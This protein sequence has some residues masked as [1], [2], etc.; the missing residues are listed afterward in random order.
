MSMNTSTRVRST[1]GKSASR[2]K[3][4]GLTFLLVALYV[5]NFGNQAVLGL[6]AQP[7][8]D[9][10]GLTASQIGVMG[11]SFFAA[12]L[13]G[14]LLAGTLNKWVTLRWSLVILALTWAVVMLPTIFAAGFAMLLIGRLL[15]GLAEGP[16][17]SLIFTAAY[18][19][20]PEDRRSLPATII[21]SAASL[22]KVAVAPVLTVVI[23]QFGWRAGFIT[24][25]GVAALWCV[26]WL[27]TW[28]D[29]PYGAQR[30]QAGHKAFEPVEKSTAAEW[31]RLLLTPTFLAASFASGSMFAIIAMGLTWI[32]SY[33]EQ[34]L[35]YSRVQSGTMFA[36]P[37]LAG[38][39]FMFLFSAVSDRLLSRGVSK[40]LVRGVLPASGLVIG[41]MSLLLLPAVGA[42]AMA[43]LVLSVGYGLGSTVMPLF[44]AAVADVAP[45]RQLAGALGVLTASCYAGGIVGPLLAGK[46]VGAGS[47]ASGYLLAFQIFGG[48]ALVAALI[49]MF[50]V[51]PVRDALRLQQPIKA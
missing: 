46:L 20:H 6:A 9:E 17:A 24:L 30:G 3:A 26:I 13:V 41:G 15:L 22:S 51:N 35:G 38:L 11:S 43:V 21:T 49:A 14:S 12:M 19:W 23:A 4:W 27:A 16:T 31:R 25:A 10:F 18:S 1:A 44:N 5:V 39:V 36:L 29:G 8:K 32:P 42:P 48:V 28:S 2:G 7:L 47:G 50:A 40:R 45:P 37:S 34:G 33:F